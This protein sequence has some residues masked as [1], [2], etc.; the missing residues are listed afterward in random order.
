MKPLLSSRGEAVDDDGNKIPKRNYPALVYFTK[1]VSCPECGKTWVHHPTLTCNT[2]QGGCGYS[3]TE[4]DL[5]QLAESGAMP[6]VIEMDLDNNVVLVR[7]DPDE[8]QR[9]IKERNPNQ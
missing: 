7:M 3:F 4:E 2:K 5:R 8:A 1:M 6:F 9:I